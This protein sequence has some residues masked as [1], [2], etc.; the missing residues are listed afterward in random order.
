[1]DD[2]FNVFILI[3]KILDESNMIQN[4]IDTLSSSKDNVEAII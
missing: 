3:A 4:K 1:M 2:V